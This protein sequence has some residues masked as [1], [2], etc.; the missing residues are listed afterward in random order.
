MKSLLWQR[1]IIVVSLAFITVLLAIAPGQPKPSFE[2]IDMA[3]PNQQTV[4][5]CPQGPPSCR[6]PQIQAAIDAA[7]EETI[8]VIKYGTYKENLLIGLLGLADW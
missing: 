4:V 1:T 7:P 3:V 5:V 6:F 2:S 8:I